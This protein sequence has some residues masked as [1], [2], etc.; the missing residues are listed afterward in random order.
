MIALKIKYL[1]F[2][3]ERSATF[4]RCGRPIEVLAPET[5]KFF[6]SQRFHSDIADMLKSIVLS[7]IDK[8]I[9][10]VKSILK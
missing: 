3:A 6:N 8:S 7:N 9:V 2:N 4:E 5:K 10:Y 1:K